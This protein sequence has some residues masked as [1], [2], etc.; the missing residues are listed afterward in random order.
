MHQ[1]KARDGCPDPM[2]RGKVSRWAAQEALGV[3]EVVE[4][5]GYLRY[6]H[7]HLKAPRQIAA[8]SLCVIPWSWE[9]SDT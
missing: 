9:V 5:I 6:G 8:G 7:R 4:A 1:F 2:R 3:N